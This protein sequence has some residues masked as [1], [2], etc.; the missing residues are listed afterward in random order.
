MVKQIHSKMQ[1]GYKSIL[2]VSPCGSGKTVIMNNIL[3]NKKPNIKELVICHRLELKDQHLN[4]L[5]TSEIGLPVSLSKKLPDADLILSDETHLCMAESWR[6][7]LT[8]YKTN[9]KFLIGFSATPTRLDGKPLG[10]LFD[11]I[12]QGPTVSWL[13]ENKY[14]APFKYYCPQLPNSDK[15]SDNAVENP[16]AYMQEYDELFQTHEIYGNIIENY[17]KFLN[18][19]KTLIFCIT[20]NHAENVAKSFQDSGISA[21]SISSKNNKQERKQILSDFKKGKIQVLCNVGILSE[22]IDIRDIEGVIQL[23]PTNSQALYIQQSM[24]GMRTDPK[25]PDKVAIILDMVANFRRHGLPN[26][27]IEFDL[28]KSH[29]QRKPVLNE[30]GDYNIRYCPHCFQAFKT[31]KICPYCNTPYVLDSRE[32][33]EHK[34]IE[35]TEIKESEKQMKKRNKQNFD[36]D[37]RKCTSVTEAVELAKEYGYHPFY[38][39]NRWRIKKW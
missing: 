30:E 38:G 18:N 6:N 25:N 2:V 20:I 16:E 28:T 4:N 39:V 37:F 22:G 26:D 14:L 19:K 31:A 36:K 24:R 21:C 27:P 9:N 33:I 13:I 17:K 23:R 29:T 5:N 34:H 7:L 35:L 15:L 3:K 1:E 11:T 10:D 12:V 32:I 8:H